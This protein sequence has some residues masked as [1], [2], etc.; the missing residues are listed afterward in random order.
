MGKRLASPA[1]WTRTPINLYFPLPAGTGA[2]EVITDLVLGYM[3]EIESAY[4]TTQ[5]A[6]TGTSASRVINILKGASTV[7][8]TYTLLLANTATVGQQVAL[9]VTPANAHFEETDTLTVEFPT[10]GAVAFTAGAIILT[11]VLRTKPATLETGLIVHV[12]LFI[13]TG[14]VLKVDTRSG[15]YLGKALAKT[16]TCPVANQVSLPAGSIPQ[17]S[18]R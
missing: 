8:A 7:A 15:E 10:A 1:G 13:N 16:G 18:S 6:G 11:I 14:D 9:T 5:V 17:R 2:V 3:Y 12:P 4:I